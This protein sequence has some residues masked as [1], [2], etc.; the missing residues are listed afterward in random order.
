MELLDQTATLKLVKVIR[1]PCLIGGQLAAGLV[2]L[3]FYE[4]IDADTILGKH[5]PSFIATRALKP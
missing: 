3:G 5:I 4:D 2:L 1:S